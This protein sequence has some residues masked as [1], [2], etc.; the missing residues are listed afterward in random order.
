MSATTRRTGLVAL[1]A[2]AMIALLAAA[3][4]LLRGVDAFR[5][6]RVEVSGTRY[7]P[8]HQALAVSGIT[9]SS[10]VF[11]DWEPWRRALRAHPLVDSV[12]V[13][14]RLPGTILLRIRETE[15]VALVGTPALRLVD[16][17]ARV[18]PVEPAGLAVDLP[19][20][21]SAAAVGPDGRLRDTT[22]VRLV[23][24]ASRIRSREPTL[25]AR[26]SEIRPDGR[27]HAR[28]VLREPDGVAVL[29]P[30]RVGPERL[31]ELRLTFADLE[32]RGDLHRL[33]RVDLR[34]RNQVVVALTPDRDT[35]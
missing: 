14:R 29:V 11:D 35:S 34:F 20:V 7:L 21:A 28:L 13:Q 1:T 9:R 16:R 25:S 24:L 19:V 10:N 4:R 26:L 5:V 23:R 22:S 32:T 33:R 17:R 6:E 31:R 27:D 15:P 8:P 3:P 12:T 30:Y 2:V 18:L